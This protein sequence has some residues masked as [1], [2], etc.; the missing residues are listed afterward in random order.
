MQCD[1][2]ASQLGW[3]LLETHKLSS[4]RQWVEWR[5]LSRVSQERISGILQVMLV[6]LYR[7]Y[8][9]LNYLDAE[10]ESS[11]MKLH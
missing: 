2:E 4:A 7:F 10:T 6:R 1:W 11:L 9:A 5:F 8:F 3:E